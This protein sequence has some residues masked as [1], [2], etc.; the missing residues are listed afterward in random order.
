MSEEGSVGGGTKEELLDPEAGGSGLQEQQPRPQEGSAG[1]QLQKEQEGCHQKV[2]NSS[3]NICLIFYFFF[4]L[5][6]LIL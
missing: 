1:L 4:Y 3:V 5:L 2:A 6:C